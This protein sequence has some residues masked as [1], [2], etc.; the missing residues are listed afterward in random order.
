MKNK[1]IFL[2]FL[3]LWLSACASVVRNP[4][5]EADYM[6][7]TVLDRTDLRQWGDRSDLRVLPHTQSPEV[8][9]ARY[10]G[11]MHREHNY[12]VISGGGANG[13]YGAGLLVAWTKLGTRPEFTLVTGVS[14]GALIAPFAFLGSEYDAKLKEIYTTLDTS[15]IINLRN[16]FAII[17]SDSVFDSSPLSRQIEKFIDD[18]M[19]EALAQEYRKGR[20]LII[21]TT[22][23]DASRP[24]L[25][26]IARI[27][28]SGH[29]SA[30]RLIHQVILAS[31]SIPGAFPPVY[32]EV[33]TPDG[34]KYD[35]MHVDGGVTSQMFFYPPNMDWGELMDMLD[36][37]GVPTVYLVR[38]AFVRE[39]YEVM[40][41][42][43]IPITN[44]TISSLIRTQGVGD[45]FRI[46]TLANRDGLDLEVTWIPD[47]AHEEIAVK[48]S[49][50]FDPK[51]M[52]ALFNYGYE[53]TINGEVW[54]DFSILID[55]EK[56]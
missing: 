56:K 9:E 19:I 3:S 55:D 4:V 32:I 1:H 29:P 36:V 47:E 48:P 54:Q 22:N 40:N 18:E 24:V 34:R 41:P 30:A 31:A 6:D 26:N 27:A 16:V 44:R 50:T 35:E 42:R 17:G 23:L 46:W 39:D 15:Q 37:R 11:I 45:F 38:N 53:R 13:A 21:G 25:W 28:A 5:P 7:V 8:L 51:Y 20:T 14:T 2:I 49:E 12:L 33:E 10:G 52:K 43:L